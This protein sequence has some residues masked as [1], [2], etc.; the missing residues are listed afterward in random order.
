M[1]LAVSLHKREALF[2]LGFVLGGAE[3]FF[4]EAAGELA[5]AVVGGSFEDLVA[6]CRRVE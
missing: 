1:E 6:A 4:R 3:L 2:E 5:F